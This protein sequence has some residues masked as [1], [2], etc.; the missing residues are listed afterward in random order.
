VED[1]TASFRESRELPGVGPLVRDGRVQEPE[2]PDRG[3]PDGLAV[4]LGEAHPEVPDP[5]GG[6]RVRHL[7]EH[8]DIGTDLARLLPKENGIEADGNPDGRPRQ[9][10]QA[11]QLTQGVTR[12]RRPRFDRRPAQSGDGEVQVDLII[13]RQKIPEPM[14]VPQDVREIFRPEN[15]SVDLVGPQVDG[16]NRAARAMDAGL[17]IAQGSGQPFREE[18]DEVGAPRGADD[19][20]QGS[21]PAGGRV[22]RRSSPR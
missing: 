8:G 14:R 6:R 12:G 16:V 10:R 18:G 11:G 7:G 22:G 13:G 21:I 5:L 19:G 15:Q 17:A 4:P 9:G 20:L 1:E 2:A 3:P